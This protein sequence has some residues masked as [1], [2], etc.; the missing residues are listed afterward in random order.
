MA[1]KNHFLQQWHNKEAKEGRR[2]SLTEI[3]QQS[4]VGWGTINRWKREEVDRFD[5]SVLSSLCAYFECGIGDLLEY[6][7]DEG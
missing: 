2:I 5:A 1:V 7:P 3:S 6:M 4:G